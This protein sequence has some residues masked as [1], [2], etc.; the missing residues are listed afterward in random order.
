MLVED[1]RIT[2]SNSAD[3]AAYG[4]ALSAITFQN[5]QILP[6]G[7][8]LQRKMTFS[9]WDQKDLENIKPDP[10]VGGTAVR[11]MDLTPVNDPPVAGKQVLLTPQP[12][13]TAVG[14]MEA[15]DPD[16]PVLTYNITCFPGKGNVTLID[17]NTGEFRYQSDPVG[18]FRLKRV[19]PSVDSACF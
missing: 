2:I 19:E 16:S 8:P 17:V 11:F 14:K 7:V 12:G 6:T 1:G 15:T 4:M 18:R 13:G 5:N 10:R 9:V 3:M